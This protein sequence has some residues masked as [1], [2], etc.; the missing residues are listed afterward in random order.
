MF[1]TIHTLVKMPTKSRRSRVTKENAKRRSGP[2]RTRPSFEP[3]P[4]PNLETNFYCN[5]NQLLDLINQIGCS[6]GSN[7]ELNAKM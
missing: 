1:A 3:S 4:F 5:S 6:C 7:F 2:T